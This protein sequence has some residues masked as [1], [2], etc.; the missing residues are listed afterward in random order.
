MRLSA[1][2]EE[3]RVGVDCGFNNYILRAIDED[4]RDFLRA[5]LIPR[6]LLSGEMMLEQGARL[7][8]AIFVEAGVISIMSPMESGR[9]VEKVSVGLETYFGFPLA[10]D[11]T[12]FIVPNHCIVQV[13]GRALLLPIADLRE[14]LEQFPSLGIATRRS[15][16][17]L[18]QQTMQAVACTSLH[19]AT[20]R[21]SRWLLQAHDRCHGG[22]LELTQQAL[23]EI[24]GLR[25]ATVS[26]ACS[27]IQTEGAV[28]YKR[29]SIVVVDR[30][31][32]ESLACECYRLAW[33]AGHLP[34]SMAE[35][36][37]SRV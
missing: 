34:L 4:A 27:V 3:P 19:S 33:R 29:G 31:K 12:D 15:A 13:P 26:N 22:E 17:A 35:R 24:L 1:E 21:V 9:K 7:D 8:H 6:E 11:I 37:Q 32:L 5:R 2:C 20:Q 23:S 25:R 14:A 28:A 30:A 10:M 36:E 18:L 16:F